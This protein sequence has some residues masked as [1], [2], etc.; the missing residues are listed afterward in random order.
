LMMGEGMPRVARAACSCAF[1]SLADPVRTQ[2][3][4]DKLPGVN[5]PRLLAVF[6]RRV[7]PLL[8]DLLDGLT[9]YWVTDQAEYA[10]DILFRDAATLARLYPQW[11]E[12][13]TLRFSAEDVMTFLGRKLTG[14]FAGELRSETKRRW[15][16]ARVKH[17]MKA[18]WIKMYDKFGCVLRIETVINDPAEF[19][20]RRQGLRHGQTVVGWFPM[21]KRVSNLRRYAT[22]GR[23]ANARY[24]AA[25]TAASD[26]AR[27]YHQLE[28][29]CR[30]VTRDGRRHRA[31]YR[32]A[33]RRQRGKRRARR[34]RTGAAQ[35]PHEAA[36]GR[37]G[38]HRG[39]HGAAWGRA[40]R[41]AQRAAPGS[42]AAHSLAPCSPTGR[43]R[44][45]A[46]A[47]VSRRARLG[48]RRAE[49]SARVRRA[50]ACPRRGA[51]R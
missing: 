26:P 3:L 15:P 31:Q 42:R 11:L 9:Y 43:R 34:G 19:R 17:R 21:A 18:N 30:P 48:P 32:R 4:A 50:A 29:L 36:R 51:S 2:K 28:A 13:A 20:I 25:L 23:A 47:W 6:A 38:P 44:S 33:R 1:T 49:L 12:H 37:A 22:I 24:L 16:G 7:N 27:A 14:Q 35:G 5:W 10:T 46:G 40:R 39:S 8:A 45:G 41:A